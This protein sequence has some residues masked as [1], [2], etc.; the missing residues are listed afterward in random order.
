[1]ITINGVNMPTPSG[2]TEG[3]MD[4]TNAERNSKGTMFIDRI[5]TKVKLELEWSTLEQTE[6]T[7]VLNALEASI[8]FSVTYVDAKTGT[9]KTG[10]FY[11]GDRNIPML[12]YIDGKAR[13]KGFKVNLIEV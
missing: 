6:M 2:Y 7:K 3:I 8:T 12:D 5:A 9:N 10:T 13:W 11:K 4:I 1:M